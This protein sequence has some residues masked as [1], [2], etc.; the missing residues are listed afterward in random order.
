M[1]RADKT[2]RAHRP[3]EG[4]GAPGRGARASE[5]CRARLARFRASREPRPRSPL[6]CLVTP[7]MVVP[8]IAPVDK[9]GAPMRPAVAVLV[10]VAAIDPWC[11]AIV[12]RGIGIVGRRIGMD[13]G[14]RLRLVVVIALNDALTHHGRRGAFDHDVA[15]AIDRPIEIGGQGWREGCGQGK[16]GYRSQS[17]PTHGVAPWMIFLKLLNPHGIQMVAPSRP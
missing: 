11:V 5:S 12:G 17:K 9:E 7:M 15:F 3:A 4:I 6:A 16:K 10:A 14:S 13:G 1:L 2:Q 8:A